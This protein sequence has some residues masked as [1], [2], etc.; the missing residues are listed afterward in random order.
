MTETRPNV[1][2]VRRVLE[3]LMDR[4]Y[5]YGG[6]FGDSSNA[7]GDCSSLT[8]FGWNPFLAHGAVPGGSGLP[9]QLLHNSAI[10][11][12]QTHPVFHG[13]IEPL[14][15]ADLCF[16]EQPIAHV[17]MFIGFGRDLKRFWGINP[18][19]WGIHPEW[20][21]CISASFPDAYVKYGAHGVGIS[22]VMMYSSKTWKPVRYGR[23]Y[24]AGYDKH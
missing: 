1:L 24:Y 18:D 12:E 22:R 11:A 10:Q 19:H 5:K 20:R 2:A 3:H 16:Y 9:I 6:N 17:T 15:V 4:Q 13:G 8:S 21:A 14:K 7:P 23:P